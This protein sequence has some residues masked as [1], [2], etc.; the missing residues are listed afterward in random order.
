MLAQVSQPPEYSHKRTALLDTGA[1]G[2]ATCH[3]EMIDNYTKYSAKFPCP[4]RLSGAITDDGG[5]SKSIIPVGEGYILVP[6]RFP[7]CGVVRVKVY[8]SPHLTGTI[9]N[10]EDLMGET[11]KQR[12]EIFG[13]SLH[14]YYGIEDDDINTWELKVQHKSND[15][16]RDIIITGIQNDAGKCYTQ[17]LLFPRDVRL[18]SPLATIHTNIDMA[19]VGD[20]EFRKDYDIAV[21]RKV[22]EYQEFQLH[23][24]KLEH[25]RILSMGKEHRDLL[26]AFDNLDHRQYIQDKT[27]LN[28]IKSDTRWQLWH[29][30]LGHQLDDAM[31][32]ASKYIDGVPKF[33]HRDPILDACS[34]CIQAKKRRMLLPV[35][36]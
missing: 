14:K 2:S 4:V 22:H 35:L 13:L 25:D 21:A 7:Q 3:K 27:P 19:M 32:T 29:A 28:N 33:S 15:N 30:R 8:Y 9:I 1:W 34:T 17:P 23:L 26:S 18:K 24:V 36:S 11:K 12:Q 5:D 31:T 6:S 20:D 10:E 16:T